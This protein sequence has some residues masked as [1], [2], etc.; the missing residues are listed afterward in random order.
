METTA[1]NGTPWIPIVILIVGFV[2]AV[3]LGSL[4]WFNSKRPAGW[5]NADRPSYVPKV[6]S[7]D[8]SLLTSQSSQTDKES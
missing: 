1:A 8:E 2:A 7:E 6:S 5:E 4:A 3:G